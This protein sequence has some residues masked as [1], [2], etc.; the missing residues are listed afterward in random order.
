MSFDRKRTVRH[1]SKFWE[2]IAFT[3]VSFGAVGLGAV[4][5]GG[6]TTD[7][8]CFTDCGSGG[9]GS[10][11]MH[12]SSSG[13]DVGG[14]F[15]GSSGQGGDCFPNCTTTSSASGCMETNGGVEMCDGV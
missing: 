8:Y 5:L 6:C 3:W 4:G 1:R 12:V 10:G 15:A 14:A 7:A 2:A 11:T 13:T 9:S